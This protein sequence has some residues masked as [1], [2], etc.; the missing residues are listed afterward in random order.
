MGVDAG[1]SHF[2]SIIEDEV[3]GY[4][5]LKYDEADMMTRDVVALM[6]APTPENYA[7]V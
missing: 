1:T 7:Q 2:F 3:E 5:T 6:R 4:S